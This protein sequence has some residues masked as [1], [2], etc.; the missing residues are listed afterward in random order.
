VIPMRGTSTQQI[1]IEA[2]LMKADPELGRVIKAIIARIGPL[3]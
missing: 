2:A 3:R 1:D